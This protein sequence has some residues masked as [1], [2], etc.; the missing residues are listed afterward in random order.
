MVRAARTLTCGTVSE[1]QPDE[2]VRGTSSLPLRPESGSSAAR[3]FAERCLERWGL[4]QT[5]F[6]DDCVL[7]VSE[8]VTNALVHADAAEELRL[9]WRPPCLVIEVRD[10]GPGLPRVHHPDTSDSGHRGLEIVS[11]LAASWTVI[12]NPA[13]G[14]TVRATLRAR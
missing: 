1:D 2:P 13:D 3:R 8:L 14:K 12:P 11:T 10:T 6:G 5:V 4:D 9:S 7:V